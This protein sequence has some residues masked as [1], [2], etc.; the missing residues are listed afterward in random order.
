MGEVHA[1][2]PTHQR[3]QLIQFLSGTEP[4]LLNFDEFDSMV[5]KDNI[6]EL[7]IDLL[8]SETLHP[9]NMPPEADILE[10]GLNPEQHLFRLLPSHTIIS[11]RTVYIFK[12]MNPAEL[13]KQIEQLKKGE[14]LNEGEVKALCLLAKEIL[15]A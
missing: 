8:T 5:M 12:Y 4:W 9:R 11:T 1:N 15:L 13:D 10:D 14:K 2:N 3:H 6:T 7:E